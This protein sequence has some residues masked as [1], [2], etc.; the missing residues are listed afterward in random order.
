MIVIIITAGKSN[1]GVQLGY[2]FV[3]QQDVRSLS[4]TEFVAGLHQAGRT[5][6][7]LALDE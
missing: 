4:P 6:E 7:S 2:R 3:R 5:L 1:L